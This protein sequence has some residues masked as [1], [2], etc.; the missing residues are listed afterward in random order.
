MTWRDEARVREA[1]MA[2]LEMAK[3]MTDRVGLVG[4]GAVVLSRRGRAIDIEPFANQI[5]TWGDQYYATRGAAGIG[6][7]NISQ[8]SLLD[9]MKLGTGV[10]AA[11]KSGA[12]AALGTY[13]SG[14]NQV[15]DTTHPA[16]TDL[17]GDTGFDL[18]Y[19][20]TWA[21]GDVTNSAIT[22]A[23][24]VDDADTDATSAAGA[25]VARVTFTAKNKTVDDALAITWAHT[26]NG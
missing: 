16:L 24:L 15:F 11:S 14:S 4:Y 25:T 9:G 5:T 7:P 8:P 23:V 17:T 26:F 21:A 13:I 20:C 22:E 6:T 19:K 1:V 12:G 18:T 2:G 3:N 10:T